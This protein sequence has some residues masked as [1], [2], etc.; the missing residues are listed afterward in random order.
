LDASREFACDGS[1]PFCFAGRPTPKHVCDAIKANQNP[2]PQR[3]CAGS[4]QK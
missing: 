1:S 2:K 4:V 3:A